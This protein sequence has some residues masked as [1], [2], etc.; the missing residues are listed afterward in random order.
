VAAIAFNLPEPAIDG[1]VLRVLSRLLDCADDVSRPDTKRQFDTVVRG[2]IPPGQASAFVQ[3]LMELGATICRARKPRCARCPLAACCRGR[4]AGTA[5]SLPRKAK[6]ASARRVDVVVAVCVEGDRI[7]VVRRPLRGL[8]AGLMAF[9]D[10]RLEPDESHGAALRRALAEFY[11]A[12]G[13]I[14]PLVTYPF[15][16]T[17]MRTTQIAYLVRHATGIPSS[18]ARWV[19]AAELGDLAFPTALAPVREALRQAPREQ[20]LLGEGQ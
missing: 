8:L 12:P 7:L 5:A 6:R 19:P 17:H 10:A 2:L 18:Q 20:A 11:L 15:A 16:F 3:A 13:D 4:A 9:P 1:N 14:E